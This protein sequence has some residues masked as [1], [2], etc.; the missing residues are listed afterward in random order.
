[1]AQHVGA[2]RP[3]FAVLPQ[4]LDFPQ[5]ENLNKATPLDV[6]SVLVLVAVLPKILPLPGPGELFFK[7]MAGG[8]EK[9]PEA[10]GQLPMVALD[11]GIRPEG[12]WQS[13]NLLVDH[14]CDSSPSAAR[15]S[16]GHQVENGSH[17][18]IQVLEHE[19]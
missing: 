10:D 3:A 1:M 5:G 18:H 16:K 6:W 8:E 9:L 12:R 7:L 13:H 2:P 4:V 17:D 14:D 19:F 11:P 15:E